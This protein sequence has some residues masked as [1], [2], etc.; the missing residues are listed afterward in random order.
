MRN[1]DFKIRFE[2]STLDL[3]YK[4]GGEIQYLVFEF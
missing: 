4:L 2:N 1:W 3:C